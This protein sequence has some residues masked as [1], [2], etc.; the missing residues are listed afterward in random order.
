M[1]RKIT[2]DADAS[3]LLKL[4]KSLILLI[5]YYVGFNVCKITHFRKV[6]I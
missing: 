4:K 3:F 1:V 6:D 2:L 5:F